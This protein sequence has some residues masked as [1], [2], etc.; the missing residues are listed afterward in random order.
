[1]LS[2]F[3]NWDEVSG[4][5]YATAALYPEKVDGVAGAGDDPKKKKKKSGHC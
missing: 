5:L 1:M 4:Q 2:L 3:R